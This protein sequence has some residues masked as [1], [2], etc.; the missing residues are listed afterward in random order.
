M[1]HAGAERGR[2]G[3]VAAQPTET[4]VAPAPPLTP[5]QGSIRHVEGRTARVAGFRRLSLV[6][7]SIETEVNGHFLLRSRHGAR[8]TPL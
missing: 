5:K 2:K 3:F 6:N 4:G 8:S 7:A 1:T